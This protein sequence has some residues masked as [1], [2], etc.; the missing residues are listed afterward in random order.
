MRDGEQA[1]TGGRKGGKRNRAGVAHRRRACEPA[2][3]VDLQ[4]RL[5]SRTASE[6]QKCLFLSRSHAN[7]T[8]TMDV[9]K[10]VEMYITRMVSE[11]SAMKVLLLDTHTV[12]GDVPSISP[13]Q[14]L[15]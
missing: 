2:A 8:G 10:A 7:K 13:A 14:K 12:R 6:V 9:F 5:I 3:N 4:V 11:P 1:W 15:T